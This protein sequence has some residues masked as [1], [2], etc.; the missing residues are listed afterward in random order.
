MVVVI[1]NVTS[2]TKSDRD[3]R[4]SSWLRDK[5]MLVVNHSIEHHTSKSTIWFGFTPI[6]KENTLERVRNLPP[7]FPVHKPRE[8]T[9]GSLAIRVTPYRKS[10][11][12]L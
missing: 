6:L 10:T 11:M 8:R 1:A 3:P 7:L 12:H 9:Y 5:S 4:N 2:L